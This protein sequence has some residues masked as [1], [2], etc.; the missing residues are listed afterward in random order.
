MRNMAFVTW[1]I[2]YHLTWILDDY[3]TEVLLGRNYSDGVEA[4]AAFTMLGIWIFVGHLLYE[5][6][7]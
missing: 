5:G 3:V 7:P 2:G 4:A 6:K 1:M